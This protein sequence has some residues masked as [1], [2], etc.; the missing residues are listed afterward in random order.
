MY[1]GE[2]IDNN[3]TRFVL[4][5]WL[6]YVLIL[7]QSYTAGLSSALTVPQ[8][9]PTITGINQIKS[10]GYNVGYQEGSFVEQ[11]LIDHLQI[12]KS[13]L[14]PYNTPEDYDNALSNGS[15]VAIFDEIPYIQVFQDS[16][17]NKYTRV[18]L[19]YNSEGFGFAFPK[20]SPLVSYL[21]MAILN[22]TDDGTLDRIK[23]RWL[24]NQSDCNRENSSSTS[25]NQIT[26]QSFGALFFFIVL[27][28]CL[29]LIIHFGH[30]YRCRMAQFLR[31]SQ[32]IAWIVNTNALSYL[33]PI[34]P[35]PLQ[36]ASVGVNT[37]AERGE[38][39]SMPN[40]VVPPDSIL[41]G[42]SGLHN[43][44]TFGLRADAKGGEE[45]V[46]SASETHQI[47]TI[48]FDQR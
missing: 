39:I 37:D 48:R 34:E 11:F 29:S 3:L 31:I 25:T 22:I 20:G 30:P 14:K 33:I 46:G 44:G 2:K 18:G 32:I 16:Y 43:S 21:S 17:C 6:F 42:L 19:T 12:D 27:F 26:V 5:A 7:T 4:M 47:S 23:Q 41:I 15:V 40:L 24:Q 13:K 45:A 38:T 8:L 10:S 35:Q 36:R 1:A 9:Q 28:S